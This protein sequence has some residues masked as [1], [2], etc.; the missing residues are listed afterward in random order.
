[1]GRG[2]W[3]HVL[4]GAGWAIFQFTAIRGSLKVAQGEDQ[5]LGKNAKTVN[6]LAWLYRKV[7][8]HENVR[9]D[10]P[11][12]PENKEK[13]RKSVP[14]RTLWDTLV[15]LCCWSDPHRQMKK[16]V[17][18]GE[19]VCVWGCATDWWLQLSQRR[20]TQ[21]DSWPPVAPDA[22]VMEACGIVFHSGG[23][24]AAQGSGHCSSQPGKQLRGSKQS[25]RKE[26]LCK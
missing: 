10:C 17:S 5:T 12:K 24:S 7:S 18:C 14:R 21:A 3:L 11:K 4:W 15:M 22:T 20:G 6:R 26:S 13:K 8:Q 19:W 1:M 23:Q 2:L 16:E 9:W 25:S